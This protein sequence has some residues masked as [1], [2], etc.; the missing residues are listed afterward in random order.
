MIVVMAVM[1]VIVVAAQVGARDQSVAVAVQLFFGF[2]SIQHFRSGWCWI[3]TTRVRHG[4]GL[5]RPPILVEGIVRGDVPCT[6][7]TSRV[8]TVPRTVVG[9]GPY[10]PRPSRGCPPTG[11]LV[12]GVRMPLVH[13]VGGYGREY[14]YSCRKRSGVVVVDGARLVQCGRPPPWAATTAS[15]YA[16]TEIG[17][18]C[19]YI[20]M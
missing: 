2:L 16:G 4:R 1:A 18:C 15:S 19:I 11:T 17:P 9:G 7:L 12:R 6:A 14:Y 8:R 10:G 5:R 20:Y 3:A 13:R